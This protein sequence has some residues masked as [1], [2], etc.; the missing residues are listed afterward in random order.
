MKNMQFNSVE[1]ETS[2]TAVAQQLRLGVGAR[3]RTV[4]MRWID[5]SR[6]FPIM[7]LVPVL[8]FFLV[9]NIIPLLW[10]LG[11]SFYNYSLVTGSPP[12]FIGFANFVDLFYNFTVWG[13]LSKTFI[14]VIFSV[15]IET[16]L[17]ILLGVLFWGSTTLP[18]RRL[19]LT[20]LFS[21]M[22]LTPAAT[23]TFFRLIYEPT[24]GV[25]N[26]L[27][28]Q[29]LGAEINFLG[30]EAW[31]MPAV[32]LVDTWMWTPFMTLITLAALG[33]VPKAELEAA[34]VD[35]LPWLKRFWYVVLPHA[36]F[37]LMLGMLLRTIDSFKVMDLIY[38]LTRG[39]PGNATEAIGLTLFRKAFEGFTMGWSAALAVITLLIAIAFTSIY[40]YI[41]NLRVQRGEG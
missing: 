37:I 6:H 35:R 12:K 41:L 20:L 15:G 16:L 33:S 19:A 38:Q 39:G 1:P 3:I 27:T 7:L 30:D 32:V 36:K 2:E 8:I 29:F 21:P 26:Y 4:R 14:F 9:W 10:M 23:G 11:M 13:G 31:A 24:F 17:G 34:E 40:L 22:I 5:N 18:G 25:A 28:T